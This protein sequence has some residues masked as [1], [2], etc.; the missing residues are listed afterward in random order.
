[1]RFL[2]AY[3]DFAETGQSLEEISY[4]TAVLEQTILLRAMSWCFMAHYEYTR[5]DRTLTNSETFDKI[6]LYLKDIECFLN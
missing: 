3:K 1:M 5:S 4:R 2:R 6:Q